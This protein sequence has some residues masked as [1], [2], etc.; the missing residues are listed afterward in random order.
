LESNDSCGIKSLGTCVVVDA[1]Q[2]SL[3][4]EGHL[5]VCFVRMLD[6]SRAIGSTSSQL[7]TLRG[8]LDSHADT[9]VVG[10]NALVIHE[11]PNVVM[12]S[13]FDPSQLPHQA[14]VVDAAIRYTCRDTGDHLILM[15]KGHLCA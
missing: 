11:H 3:E 8:E 2:Y 12:V 1:C 13:G 10:K 7:S 14:K 5:E 6:L 9:C 4:E 15:I